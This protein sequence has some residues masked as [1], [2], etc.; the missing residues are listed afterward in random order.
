MTNDKKKLP[1]NAT[2]ISQEKTDNEHPDIPSTPDEVVENEVLEPNPDLMQD[3]PVDVKIKAFV[4]GEIN[5]ADLYGMSHEELYQIAE[6]GQLLF[7]EGKTDDAET[8]FNALTALDPYDENFHSALGSV[9]QKQGRN[10]EAIIEYDRA[11]QLNNFLIAAY[12]NRAELHII[13]GKFDDVMTDLEKVFTLDPE[14]ADPY[15]QRAK[16]LAIAIATIA[17]EAAENKDKTK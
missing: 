12:V 4:Q 3:I 13:Q 10:D 8:I 5:L 15:S 17:Q 2:A 14:G 6:Y 9:Y 7:S 16:G 11:I 1:E